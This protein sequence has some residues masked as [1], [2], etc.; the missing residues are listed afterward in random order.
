MYLRF[1]RLFS[2]LLLICAIPLCANAEMD[3]ELMKEVM[4]DYVEY[5]T[6]DLISLVDQ[7]VDGMETV[8]MD[9]QMDFV[10]FRFDTEKAFSIL[11]SISHY[12]P[13][14]GQAEVDLNLMDLVSSAN[15]MIYDMYNLQMR[16]LSYYTDAVVIDTKAFTALC[17]ETWKDLEGFKF[18]YGMAKAKTTTYYWVP[19]YYDNGEGGIYGPEVYLYI[20]MVQDGADKEYLSRHAY[21]VVYGECCTEKLLIT[22]QNFVANFLRKMSEEKDIFS[23]EDDV[24]Y[25]DLARDSSGAAVYALQEALADEGFMSS[26][27]DGYFGPMT[28]AAVIAWQNAMGLEETGIADVDMQR[29]LLEDDTNQMLLQT[30]LEEQ[31]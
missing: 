6:V 28:E 25:S 14:V 1:C 9:Y 17:R 3:S 15:W 30:W 31:D 5:S 27:L 12:A 19:V 22:D 18:A 16:D 24:V 26:S 23:V 21:Y 20:Y 29:R 7:Y 4:P 8:E 2:M 13:S 10:Q 11:N